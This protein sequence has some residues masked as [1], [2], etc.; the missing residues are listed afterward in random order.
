MKYTRFIK[1]SFWIAILAC[2]SNLFIAC[3]DDI[4]ISS[5]NKSFGNIEGNFGY[6]KSAAGAK[7]LTS[8]TINGD[9]H[10]TGH[11]YFELNKAANKDITVTFKIDESVLK[12][13]NQANGT[14]YPMYPTDKLSLENEG[15]TTIS[16]GKQKSSSIELDIQSGGTIGTTYAVAVSATASDGIE[17]SSNNQSYIYLVTPQATLPN[18]EKGTVKTICYIEVNNENILN[19]G[20]YTMENSGKPFF[21]IVNV[22]A[23]NIRLN[24]E[25]KPYVYCNPQVTFVLENADKLIRPLQQKGIK[26][27]LTILGDHTP[28]GMRSLG[29]E[30]AKDFAKELKSYVDIYGF[31]GISFDDEWSNYD[32]VA[33]YPGLVTP[34][35]EQYSRL[36]YECR[37]IMPDKQF[38]VYWCKQENG[39]ASINYPL[40]EVEGKDVNDLLDYTVYGNYNLWDKL[41][42]IDEGKQCPYA[43]NLTEGGNPNSIYLNQIKDSWGY[44][45]LY[46]LQISKNSET[47]INQV[48]E[49]LYGEKVNWTGQIY[50]RTDFTSSETTTRINYKYYLGEWNVTASCISSVNNSWNQWAGNMKFTIKIEEKV[51][52]ESYYVYG[53]QP[54]DQILKKYPLI[55]NYNQETTQISIPIPQ[56][57]HEP[58]E[59]NPLLWQMSYATIGDPKTANTWKKVETTGNI[60]GAFYNG[61]LYLEANGTARMQTLIPFCSNDKGSTWLYL[62]TNFTDKHPKA[63]FTL[64]RN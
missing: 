42:H 54:Y 62:H 58:D 16:A 57:I 39:G 64:T 18:T 6:V 24:E 50:G 47:I 32:L 55:M 21:D 41:G 22:F 25:G 60:I 31:D 48:G 36:I 26:V 61:T 9:K 49:T 37:Q 46:N 33:G 14:N 44:F 10:G 3:E 11:L 13:Y 59:E 19:T 34:S 45:A 23:A 35:Q 30:A 40:G 51:E 8:I 52:N 28:A 20:E 15:V 7:A 5:E 2:T 29:D 56:T 4:T 53:I 43:I 63:S 17:T 27:H 38:G 12:A 1:S